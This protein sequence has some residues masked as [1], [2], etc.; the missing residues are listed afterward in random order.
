MLELHESIIIPLIFQGWS[1]QS[2]LTFDSFSSLSLFCGFGN[3]VVDTEV[4]ISDLAIAVDMVFVCPGVVKS[5]SSL[6]L[7]VN[8][9][10]LSQSKLGVST[11]VLNCDFMKTTRGS[12]HPTVPEPHEQLGEIPIH[13]LKCWLNFILTVTFRAMQ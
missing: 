10:L 13:Q 11:S 5:C 9:V 8:F 2:C 7:R 1:Q 12:T 4:R 6:I 3:L